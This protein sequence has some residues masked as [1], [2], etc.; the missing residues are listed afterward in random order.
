MS[1]NE[2]R[3]SAI[4]VHVR[5][6]GHHHTGNIKYGYITL[7][8]SIAVALILAVSN[9]F[10]LHKWQ[11]DG[12]PSPKSVWR[13][14]GR[15]PIWAHMAF[16]SVIVLGLSFFHVKKL[17]ENYN[18]VIK[19]LGR[20]GYAL[21]PLD[22]LL[23]IRPSLL[24]GS[25]LDYISLH[26]WLLRLIVVAVVLHGI[27]FFTKWLIEGTFWTKTF[28][29]AN[30]MGVIVAVIG[31]VLA[32]VSIGPVRRRVYGIFYII[33]N[34]T[35]VTFLVLIWL[36]ARPGVLDFVILL[37]SMLAF[38]VYQRLTLV[39]QIPRITIVDKDTAS[40]RVLHLTKPSEFPTRWF[41]GS[42][43]RLGYAK[44][45]F[46]YWLLPAHPYTLCSLPA[47]TTLDL[48]VK[49]GFRFQVFS[50]LEYTVS[51]PFQSIPP[52]CFLTAENVNVFC[53]GSGISLGI[54]VVRY[55]KH[56]SSAKV[57]L[58]WCITN[59]EDAY[60]LEELK[61]THRVDVYVTG[62]SDTMFLGSQ[63]EED[64]GL[65]NQVDDIELGSLLAES[66]SDPFADS[67]TLDKNL[68]IVFHRGRPALDHIFSSFSETS[69]P[70]NKWIIACGPE[71]LIQDAKTWSKLHDVQLFTEL[72]DM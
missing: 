14:I 58:F 2:Y 7:G 52:P 49:K 17:S 44:S 57:N 3:P 1:S 50:S 43:I 59:K 31:V 66:A 30:F 33:H 45:N 48:V 61:V 56:S 9:H 19:R 54:P 4:D 10:Y 25:Y 60:V 55:L 67:Q 72:Y 41:A 71:S 18:V 24:G 65:L 53:G 12:H 15:V 36:H 13:R 29:W 51:N 38:Q 64:D 27:G 46:R 22:V 6:A 20:V 28:R 39:H 40:L 68:D 70:A 37:L 26:K 63:N 23:V 32:V 16:W 47:D 42:H 69:E 5:H 8:T 21:V 34:V 35:V 62:N 11:R